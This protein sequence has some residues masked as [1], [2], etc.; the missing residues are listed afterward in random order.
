MLQ[1]EF[2]LFQADWGIVFGHAK[3][4]RNVTLIICI[5]FVLG[6][7][8]QRGQI[9]NPGN[10]CRVWFRSCLKS[11]R[12]EANGRSTRCTRMLSWSR[13]S[14]RDLPNDWIV[15]RQF[16]RDLTCTWRWRP[17]SCEFLSWE[18]L[19]STISSMGEMIC[20]PWWPITQILLHHTRAWLWAWCHVE[21]SLV[22]ELGSA[23]KWWL[24]RQ[25]TIPWWLWWWMKLIHGLPKLIVFAQCISSIIIWYFHIVIRALLWAKQPTGWSHIGCLQWRS[26]H[27]HRMWTKDGSN[28][29]I[30]SIGDFEWSRV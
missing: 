24:Q 21:W 22:L 15:S 30:N 13:G 4:R 11:F 18:Q 14:G 6:N 20:L 23:W 16:C 25:V 1:K 19:R 28:Q 27:R 8:W 10:I 29:F 9:G 2:C 26:F 12:W 3:V 17:M 5:V 7:L